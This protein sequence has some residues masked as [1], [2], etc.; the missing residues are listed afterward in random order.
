VKVATVRRRDVDGGLTAIRNVDG[1][2]V[3]VVS[4]EAAEGGWPVDRNI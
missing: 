3:H 4:A 1:E 2:N